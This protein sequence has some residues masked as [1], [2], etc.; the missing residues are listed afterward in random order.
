MESIKL[1]SLVEQQTGETSIDRLVT[2]SSI[3]NLNL[4]KWE[5]MGLKPYYY[6]GDET[7]PNF[8]MNLITKPYD[9]DPS[10]Y[11]KEIFLLSD[12]DLNKITRVTA[13]VMEIIIQTKKA[14]RIYQNQMIPS[15]ANEIIKR[16]H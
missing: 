1:L 5:N 10:N 2:R 12:D 4:Q 16:Q 8:G 6:V 11:K 7:K 3:T 15:V 9:R 14:L 13:N